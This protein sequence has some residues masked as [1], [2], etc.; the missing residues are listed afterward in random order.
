[1]TKKSYDF[2]G[3]EDKLESRMFYT[4]DITLPEDMPDG[5]YSY[6]LYDEN[7]TAKATGLIQVGDY[8]PEKQVYKKS[9]NDYIQYQG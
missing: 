9:N 1:M 4:L 5:E 6:V 8:K 3:I 7:D 2:E